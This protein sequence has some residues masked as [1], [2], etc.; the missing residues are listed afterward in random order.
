MKRDEGDAWLLE[1]V[2]ERI[3]GLLSCLINSGWSKVEI[4][5]M[6]AQA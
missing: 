3:I 1:P 4:L 6:T 2:T 5:C